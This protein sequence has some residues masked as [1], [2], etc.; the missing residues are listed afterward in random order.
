MRNPRSTGE[1]CHHQSLGLVIL[2]FDSAL[3]MD[4]RTSKEAFQGGLSPLRT[5]KD[6]GGVDIK[7][8][9]VT[10]DGTV[11]DLTWGRFVI[12]EISPSSFRASPMCLST[13]T[14]TLPQSHPQ[15][16]FLSSKNRL[17]IPDLPLHYPWL[18]TPPAVAG[19]RLSRMK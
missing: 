12:P 18:R 15:I 13:S 6:W 8:N 9:G 4:T 14:P 1:C 2:R 5:C 16:R 10:V 19:A 17:T 3:R 7:Q 11:P